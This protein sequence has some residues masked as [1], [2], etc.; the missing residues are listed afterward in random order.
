[1]GLIADTGVFIRAERLGLADPIAGLPITEE[2]AISAITLSELFEGVYLASRPD[3]ASWRRFRVEHIAA[4]VPVI[5]FTAEIAR[6]HAQLRANLVRTGRIIGA[7]DLIIAATAV[8]LGWG[9]LTANAKEF[10]Q[11]EELKVREI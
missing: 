11:V 4:T 5:S 1:M 3:R 10:R 7:H 8:S 9:I 6:V 2:T